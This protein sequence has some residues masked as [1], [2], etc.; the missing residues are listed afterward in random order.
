MDDLESA[1][2]HFLMGIWLVNSCL[3]TL[4]LSRGLVWLWRQPKC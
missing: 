2:V 4:V 3:I 1:V